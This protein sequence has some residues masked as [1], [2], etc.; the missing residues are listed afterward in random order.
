ML[1]EEVGET[2]IVENL[3]P[4]FATGRPDGVQVIL[5]LS[6]DSELDGVGSAEC[7]GLVTGSAEIRAQQVG[8]RSSQ[9]LVERRHRGVNRQ[10]TVTAQ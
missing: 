3:Q 9:L 10:R 7:E 5:G 6:L 1:G 4:V 8:V 2:V